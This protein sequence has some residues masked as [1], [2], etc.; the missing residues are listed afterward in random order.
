MTDERC[1]SDALDRSADTTNG[2]SIPEPVLELAEVSAVVD[3]GPADDDAV[4][5]A[6]PTDP[7]DLSCTSKFVTS[8]HPTAEDISTAA[9]SVT[10]ASRTHAA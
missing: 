4:E 5:L 8:T 3:T 10:Y 7:V 9:P 6:P 2:A 1:T